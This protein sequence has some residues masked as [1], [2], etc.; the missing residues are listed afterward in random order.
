M[1]ATVKATWM[2]GGKTMQGQTTI[3]HLIHES[4]MEWTNGQPR[5]FVTTRCGK[6]FFDPKLSKA[7]EVAHYYRP[8]KT[9]QKKC[10][11]LVYRVYSAKSRLLYV[12]MTNDLATRLS[13]HK[14][15]KAKWWRRDIW[16]VL[17]HYKSREAAAVAELAAIHEERPLFNV[18]RSVV[19]YSMAERR[20]RAAA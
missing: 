16:L 19:S 5:L 6:E 7:T 3:P 17:R 9:C 8:C 15:A 20:R 1:R 11:C 10:V 13:A 18:H 12:G 4:R 2:T 14:Y